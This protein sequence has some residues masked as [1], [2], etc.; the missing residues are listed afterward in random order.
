[1]IIAVLMRALRPVECIDAPTRERFARAYEA[2]ATP[3]VLRGVASSWPATERWSLDRLA[4]EHGDLRVLAARL[5]R[6]AVAMD[7]RRGLAHAPVTLGAFLEGLREGARDRYVSTPLAGLPPALAR[8]APL[9]PYCDGASWHDGNLWIGAEGTVSGLHF[10]VAD[11]FHAVV[12]GGKRFVLAPPRQS[13]SLYPNGPLHGV[14]NG[15]RV[16]LEHP[17][18]E[19]FP[20]VRDA[21]PVVAELGPGD[22]LYIPRLWWH[23]VRTLGTCV[24]VNFWWASGAYGA[25][26]TAARWFKRARGVSL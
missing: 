2:S 25:L 8:D 1:M 13:A 6:G 18:F 23:Q 9:P 14:P 26:V 17:D 12:S 11:N 15:A 10:D 21:R 24:S 5:D 20:R 16:D 22:M 19:R 3:V 7:A 4:R